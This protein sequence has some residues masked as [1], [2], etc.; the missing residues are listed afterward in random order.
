M[1]NT[2]Q[3][4]RGVAVMPIT[5][6]FVLC[7]RLGTGRCACAQQGAEPCDQMVQ[8]LAQNGNVEDARAA[9]LARIERIARNART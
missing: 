6:A 4:R 3:H 9:E 8:L 2:I 1:R 5:D 7:R